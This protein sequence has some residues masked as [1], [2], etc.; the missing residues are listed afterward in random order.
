MC[1]IS[2]CVCAIHSSFEHV[3][4]VCAVFLDISKVFDSVS[5]VAL[6]NKLY[7]INSPLHFCLWFSSYLSG[8]TQTVCM[9]HQLSTPLP[10]LSGVPQCSMLG[11]LFFSI[12]FSD[13]ASLLPSFSSSMFLYLKKHTHSNI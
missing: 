1:L 9:V 12:F 10:V 3:S 7:S 4:S 13:I 11:P 5:H 6:L 8:R 2:A